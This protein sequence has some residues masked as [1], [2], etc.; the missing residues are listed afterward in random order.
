MYIPISCSDVASLKKVIHNKVAFN[1]L[2]ITSKGAQ[3]RRKTRINVDSL[4]E[5]ICH[6]IT[7]K[8]GMSHCL[9]YME[10]MKH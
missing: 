9:L 6:K 10:G 7:F 3:R 8:F 1:L 5:Q 4:Q 2:K